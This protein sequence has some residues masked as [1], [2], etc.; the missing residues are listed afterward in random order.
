M[1]LALLSKM[2]PSCQSRKQIYGKRPS[3]VK[4]VMNVWKDFFLRKKWK[5]QFSN[6]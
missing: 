5:S 2:K 6:P 3:I 4:A 1:D